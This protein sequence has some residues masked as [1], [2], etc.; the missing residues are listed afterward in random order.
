M[1]QE[2]TAS[3]IVKTF[4][5]AFLVRRDVEASLACLTQ[6]IQWVG[7]GKDMI[8][9]GRAQAEQALCAE[10]AQMTGRFRIEYESIQESVASDACA[11]VLLTVS[12]YP[13]E[14]IDAIWLR[15]TA[16]CVERQDGTCQIASL[17]ASTPDNQQGGDGCCTGSPLDHAEMEQQMGEKALD[18]LGKN[19]PGGMMGGYLEPNYPLYYVN[20]YML[21]YLGFTYDEFMS[22]IDGKVINCIHPD[23][24]VRVDMLVERAFRVGST[25]EVQYRMLKKDGSYIWVKDV[26]K[27]T[28]SKDGRDVCLSVIRDISVEM[29]AHKYLKQQAER[30][31]RLFQSM[32]CGIAQYRISGR[33]VAFK[34]V[35][36]E[37][38]RI[39][40][41][42]AK[43]FWEKQDWNLE[44]L[45]A[46][47]DRERVLK[48]SSR[49]RS[50]GDRETFEYR[51]IQKDGTPCWIIGSAEVIV[52]MDGKQ[53]IQSVFLN[54][55]DRKNMELYNEQLT[56]QVEASNEILH[57]ALEH[58]TICEFF[59]YP[60]T[61]SCR[62]P[63]RTCS[64]YHCRSHYLRMPQDFMT[65]LVDEAYR[66]AFY[67]SYEHI[68]HGE[69]TAI[70]EFRTL[71]GSQ[72]CRQTLSVIRCGK[73]GSPQL[74]I[75]IVEDITNQK[76]MEQALDD[77]RS[78]DSLTG[79]YKREYGVR[80]VKEYLNDRPAGEHAVLML[81]D[82]DDFEAVNQK[83]GTIFADA[84]LQEVA[85]L[86]RTETGPDQIQVRLGGDEFMLLIKNSDKAQATIKGPRIANLVR[87]IL[88][89][90][91][92][93]VHIS[94]S[95]G[96]CSTEVTQDYN[97][98]Y[99]CAES[100]LKY[101]KEHGKGQAACYLDTSN[102]VGMFLTQI[103]TEKHPVNEIETVSTLAGSDLIS[104]ALDLLGKAKNLDDAVS[105]LLARIGNACKFDRVSIIEADRDYLTY[106]FTYQWA[107]SHT[108]LQLGQDFYVSD[109]DFELCSA[110]YDEDGLADHNLRDGISNIASCLHAGIWDYG[111]Y[112]GSISFEVD[113]PGYQWTP[114]HRK[115]LQEL[116]QLVPSFIMKSKA[117]AVSQAKTDFLSRMSHEI[118]TP[119]NAISGMTTIAKS[120]VQDPVK[121]LDCLE[122]IE[123]SN[124]YLLSLVNDILDMSRIES[125]KLELNYGVLDLTQLLASLESLFHA[126]VLEKNLILSVRDGRIKK[127]PIQADCLRLNQVLVNVIGNAVKFTDRGGITIC[128][129][130]L[131]TDPRAVLRFSVTDTGIGIDSAAQ[132]RIFNPFE[133]AE[134]STASK[135]GGTG[136]GLSITFRLVQLMGGNLE[137]RSEP[138][139]G[140]VFFFTLSF[141]YA[142]ETSGKCTETISSAPPLDF[143]GRN[144]LLAEDNELNQEIAQTILE[145]YG[146]TVTCADNGQEAVNL[147]CSEEPGRFDAILMDIRMPVMDGL[148]ATRRIRTSGRTDARA[149]PIIALSAN[150]FDEDTR[151]SM[152][153]GMDGHL[154]KPIEVDKLLNILKE[155]IAAR[156]GYNT[157]NKENV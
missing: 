93:E 41:Y 26:G 60:E 17:H 48:G 114:E 6:K 20:D 94:V 33:Q 155:C 154:S 134:A 67:E 39:F 74:V 24:R 46:E 119:M 142:A 75:G 5:D 81:L 59:Y 31:D 2:G 126:Q 8:V 14:E 35:N 21:S 79:L 89:D 143:N 140:S 149:I 109:E 49:L 25:Y 54:I 135:R 73:A 116:V 23:D 37:C 111:E 76:E 77:A 1:M 78:R 72:W 151:K 10:L 144:V 110:M 108:M 102:A 61:G 36:R 115:L 19:I 141:D 16:T 27:K 34:N 63:E 66:P 138:G 96:M 101:V 42:T 43:E 105:L 12:I 58:T 133:Q 107:R 145:T 132:R 128:V 28:L 3:K 11:V 157:Q 147:F 99:R 120:V 65:E 45:I 97:E 127:R 9:N 156:M 125:G 124:R 87:G 56:D 52:D 148:E 64:I 129:E 123:S 32:L 44:E 131:E 84:V 88:T 40:G 69:H 18:I 71:D 106:H 122:K 90:V 82:M 118:R 112:V 7:T 38:I 130:E 68:N 152:T 22:A 86:L 53:M 50:P 85:D 55:N 137:V 15:V 30:Y 100:T 98:L 91:S 117:D 13:Q 83:E 4:F 92:Q 51:L 136:L 104:F 121:T 139:R 113:V 95:I 70:C 62:V 150:A 47:E 153:S 146:F 103:Y 57:L 29:E 80:L